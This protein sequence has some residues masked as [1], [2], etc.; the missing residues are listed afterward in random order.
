MMR[1]PYFALYCLLVLGFYTTARFEGWTLFASSGRA[2]A[3]AASG[4]RASG[5]VT[6][7]HK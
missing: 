3:A 2:A 5:G 6:G 4:G 7:Y 1:A